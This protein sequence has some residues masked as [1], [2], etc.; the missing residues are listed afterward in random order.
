MRFELF[1]LALCTAAAVD[2]SDE[3]PGVGF[4]EGFV[5]Q[6]LAGEIGREALETGVVAQ[7]PAVLGL[8]VAQ[9]VAGEPF[10]AEVGVGAA[11]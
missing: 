8:C 7:D 3:S 11:G 2:L 9:G 5:F 1:L 10:H 6:L 4:G